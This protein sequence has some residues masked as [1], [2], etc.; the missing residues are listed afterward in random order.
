MFLFVGGILV[1][2]LLPYL[3][4]SVN[5]S[6]FLFTN[7]ISIS[8][9]TLYAY[10]NSTVYAET[11]ILVHNP[12]HTELPVGSEEETLIKNDTFGSKESNMGSDEQPLQEWRNRPNPTQVDLVKATELFQK[13]K[14]KER[15]KI[16]DEMSIRINELNKPSPPK[17][18]DPELDVLENRLKQLKTEGPT[19]EPDEA[20]I[21]LQSQAMPPQSRD[22]ARLQKLNYQAKSSGVDP[23]ARTEEEELKRLEK[24]MDTTDD[25]APIPEEQLQELQAK[26]RKL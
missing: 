12:M 14:E 17:D 25:D 19:S 18:R 1:I 9:F 23:N 22:E 26:V 10:Y 6:I 4:I 16:A 11:S 21:K 24:S 7:F 13:E 2:S 15:L 8:L 3:G 5:Q 20:Y